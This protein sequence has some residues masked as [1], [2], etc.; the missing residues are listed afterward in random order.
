MR[1]TAAAPQV[2]SRA[3]SSAMAWATVSAR[4]A[5][6]P[7]GPKST[8]SVTVGR[9]RSARPKQTRPSGFWTRDAAGA[10]DAGDGD[11]EGW[12]AR[13]ERA[14]GHLAGDL[15]GD[16]AVGGERFGPDAQHLLLGGVRVGD[17]AAVEDQST[18]RRC[19]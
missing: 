7:C 13:R 1:S 17:E 14:L 15:F 3:D 12:R 10:G 9:P 16:R 2:A 8:V 11:G 19:R 4:T 18:I 6:R 5:A